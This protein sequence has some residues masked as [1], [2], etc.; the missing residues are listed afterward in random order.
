MSPPPIS[1]L[2]VSSGLL[3][4]GDGHGLELEPEVADPGEE[5]VQLRLVGDLADQLGGAGATH[6]RQPLEGRRESVAQSAANHDPDAPPRVHADDDPAEL[7]ERTSPT[8]DLTQGDCALLG[9]RYSFRG[10]LRRAGG[11]EVGRGERGGR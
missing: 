7:R 5:A 8:A 3:G 1:C 10:P 11:G 2:L 6:R 9:P 4:A